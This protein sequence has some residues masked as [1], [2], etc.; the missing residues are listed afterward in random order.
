MR[1]LCALASLAGCYAALAPQGAPCEPEDPV[2]PE[3]QACRL[4]SGSYV[5]TSGRGTEPGVDAAL[6]DAGADAASARWAV[7]QTAESTAKSTNLV[8][9][10]AGHAIIVAFET[11]DGNVVTAVTD[12][13]GNTY[14]RIPTT[15]ATVS[16]GDLGSEIWYATNSHAGATVLTATATTLYATVIWEVA[17]IKT[18]SALDVASAVSNQGSTTTPQGASLTT[19]A[20]GDFVVEIAMV[21]N[22]ITG[23]HTGSPFTNDR[24]TQSNGW[25]HLPDPAAPAGMY[26]AQWDQPQSGVYCAS[27][28]AFF[29][30]P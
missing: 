27:S 30:G 15:R 20:A 8:A 6:A 2:C 19:T 4:V 16:G 17:G 11:P 23:T 3:N 7:V 29:V 12:D 24:V 14:T 22:D 18:A 25:A 10:G 1:V 5:C 21:A 13:A 26:R 9:T 28:A